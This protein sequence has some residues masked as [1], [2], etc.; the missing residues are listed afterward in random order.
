MRVSCVSRYAIV[1]PYTA[2]ACP[3]DQV[4]VLLYPWT[5]CF[6]LTA[7]VVESNTTRWFVLPSART[8]S[9]IVRSACWSA[10]VP[11]AGSPPCFE[12]HQSSSRF[13]MPSTITLKSVGESVEV[14]FQERT[15]RTTE[16]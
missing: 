14:L 1:N 5:V 15:A 6:R 13:I 16:L 12:A 10:F 8:C 3:R 11:W 7:P 2:Q 9:A 4:E